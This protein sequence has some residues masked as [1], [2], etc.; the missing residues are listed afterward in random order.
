MIE[1]YSRWASEVS[2]ANAELNPRGVSSWYPDHSKRER[3]CSVSLVGSLQYLE[4]LA[5]VVDQQVVVQSRSTSRWF[6]V[7]FF[8]CMLCTK[9]VAGE[10]GV[11][12]V[13]FVQLDDQ[14]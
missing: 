8:A 1:E 14:L 13:A 10:Q 9:D 5:D 11:S 3:D 2:P 12:V 7:E 6:P 4:D